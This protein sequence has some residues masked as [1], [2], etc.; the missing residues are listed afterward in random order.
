MKI[1]KIM[2]CII[3]VAVFISFLTFPSLAVSKPVAVKF[4]KLSKT[5]ITLALGKTAKLMVTINPSNATNKAIKWL[6][7]NSYIATVKNGKV[8]AIH[9]GNCIIIAKSSNGKMAKCSVTAKVDSLSWKAGEYEVGKDIPMG[10]YV[11]MNCN[12]F[13][14]YSDA[15]KKSKIIDDGMQNS[16]QIITVKSG[17]YFVVKSGTI[18]PIATAPKYEYNNGTHYLVY[19]GTYK[20]GTDIPAGA[21]DLSTGIGRVGSYAVYSDS[22]REKSTLI[23]SER[24][25]SQAYVTVSD[26][27]YLEIFS[28]TFSKDK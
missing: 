14:I 17:E 1:K 9:D 18:Y 6:S 19:N 5:S 23:K 11:I 24:F 15:S 27:Q 2:C 21:Y 4:L 20:I 28:C 22:T 8:T 13:S 10:E 26:G 25:S 3:S 7:S 16:R 12:G